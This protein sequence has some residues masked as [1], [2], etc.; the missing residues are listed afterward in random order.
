MLNTESLREVLKKIFGI[1]DKYLVP[2]DE[3]GY[4][5]TYDKTDTVG[6]WIGYRILNKKSYTRSFQKDQGNGNQV[7]IKPIKIYF[8]V[9]FIGKQAEELADQ[10]LLWDDRQDVQEAFNE[11]Q[12]QI[13]Y[14][15]RQHYSYPVKNG[16]LNDNLCWVVDLEAQTF[17]TN[18][19]KYQ[20]WNLKN[21][22]LQGKIKIPKEDG[23]GDE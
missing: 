2:L 7:R 18:S 1:E 12:A 11:V 13:N 14:T 6:T 22:D 8:R 20:L 19:F 21:I 15:S 4:V 17:Y 9:A 10:V 23:N 16:G 5:P 3:G